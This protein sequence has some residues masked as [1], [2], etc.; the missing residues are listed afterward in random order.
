[1]YVII[2]NSLNLWNEFRARWKFS[3]WGYHGCRSMTSTHAAKYCD[4]LGFSLSLL[5]PEMEEC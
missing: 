4:T 2:H 1:M 5:F 3:W